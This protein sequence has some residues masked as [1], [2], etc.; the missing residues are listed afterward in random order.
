MSKIDMKAA[1][2]RTRNLNYNSVFFGTDDFSVA[3]LNE[4]K[5]ASLTPQIIVCAPDRPSG[6]GHR[7]QKCATK[8]WAEENDVAVMQPEKLDD[9]FVKELSD[10]APK[11]SPTASENG[12]GYFSVASYGKILPQSV[13]DIPKHGMLNVHPSLIPLY[14]GASPVESAMLDDAK[15]TG[16]TI[17]LVDAEMDHGPILNQEVVEFD[18]WPSKLEVEDKLAKIGGELLV[19]A[20]EPWINKEIKEQ[21]QNHSEAT[22]TKKITKEDGLIDITEENFDKGKIGRQNFLKIQA[23][24]PWPGAYFFIKHGEGEKSRDIRVKVTSA[25]WIADENRLQILSVIPEGRKEMG[26]EDFE[27]G[28]L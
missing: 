7:M 18:E 15:Q 28:F 25:K 22:F 20:I 27:K 9:G 3:V 19:Q 6:R 14:R 8:I 21:E 12:W 1:A 2:K 16:V 17:I 24:N 5:S 4:L 10:A 23:L 11:N 26:W 13:I